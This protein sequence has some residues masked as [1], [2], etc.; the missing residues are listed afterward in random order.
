MNKSAKKKRIPDAS[1]GRGKKKNE[2]P[3]QPVRDQ[4]QDSEDIERAV[5]DG[6]QDL[7]VEK[8]RE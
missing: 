2:N 1:K 5:Y 7:R 4:G 8:S 3:L 6:M